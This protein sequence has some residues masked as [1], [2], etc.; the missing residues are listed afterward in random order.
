MLLTALFIVVTSIVAYSALS[1]WAWAWTSQFDGLEPELTICLSILITLTFAI[2]AGA[3]A[4]W[5]HALTTLVI[6]WV[7]AKMFAPRIDGQWL[8]RYER[9]SEEA[10]DD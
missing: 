10:S 3:V 4:G 9:W 5:I 2:A 7:L 6:P 8:E 1:F